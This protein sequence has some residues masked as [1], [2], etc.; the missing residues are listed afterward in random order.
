[1]STF[2]ELPSELQIEIFSN[3][4][5][6]HLGK[7]LSI[8]KSTHDQLLQSEVFWKSLI[9]NYSKLSGDSNQSCDELFDISEVKNQLIDMIRYKNMKTQF[10]RKKCIEF[11]YT[12]RE[13]LEV[14]AEL[15][16]VLQFRPEK[17]ESQ[18]INREIESI[19]EEVANTRKK[20]DA[21]EESL[22]KMTID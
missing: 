18:K 1:M 15:Q 10:L 14:Q 16:S 17:N 5:V 19:Q 6:I 21:L 4:S 7:I 11:E 2:S 3:L 12:L 22:E 13:L 9:K 20:M 8:N